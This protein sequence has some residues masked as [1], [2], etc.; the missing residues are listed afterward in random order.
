MAE[1]HGLGVLT[2]NWWRGDDNGVGINPNTEVWG[3]GRR[4]FSPEELVRYIRNLEIIRG[5][6]KI[7][8]GTYL[9]Q[10]ERYEA[11]ALEKGISLGDLE[12]RINRANRNPSGRVS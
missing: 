6:G 3:D 12:R 1:R 10:K 7:T 5:A 11:I 9:G 2:P 8:I 4:L